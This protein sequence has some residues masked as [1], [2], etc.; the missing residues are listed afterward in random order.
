MNTPCK[1]DEN[2][3]CYSHIRATGDETIPCNI[4][5]HTIEHVTRKTHGTMLQ[6]NAARTHHVIQDKN[7]QCDMW[8]EH[9]MRHVTGTHY[10][11]CDRNTPCDMW[12]E[13]TMRHAT[14]TQ[15]ATMLHLSRWGT[16]WM[17][18]ETVLWPLERDWGSCSIAGSRLPTRVE[19]CHSPDL[20]R[21]LPWSRVLP[22]P[23]PDL[24]ITLPWSRI[25]P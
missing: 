19:Y 25:L 1:I 18:R 8:Q 14:G 7:T 10:A 5:E 4:Q 20:S 22:Y 9:T 3:P 13:H 24:S 12:Q 2:T 23:S 15:H 6:P 11:T 16:C 17:M 21:V